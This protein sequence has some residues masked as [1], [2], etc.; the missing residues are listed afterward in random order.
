[1][2]NPRK[3]LT[4][5]EIQEDSFVTF[6]VNAQKFYETYAKQIQY[7]LLAVVAVIVISTLMV[8][9]KKQAEIQASGRLGIAE[10]FVTANQW[11]QATPELQ[12]IVDSYSGTRAAGR[13]VLYLAKGAIANEKKAE[14]EQY[15]RQYAAKYKSDSYL[16]SAAMAGV[17]AC[18]EDDGRYAEAIDWYKKAYKQDPKSFKA[19][20]YL[21]GAARCAG[22]AVQKEQARAFYQQIVDEYPDS[23]EAREVKVFLAAL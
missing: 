19:P 8:R 9:S 12:A 20:L 15:Y 3:R 16:L 17:A 23:P 14:A 21:K 5:K 11:E 22:R 2:L 10:L 13:A 7:G 1:M 4:K 18:S 6:M